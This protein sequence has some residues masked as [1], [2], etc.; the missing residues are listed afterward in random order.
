MH[1][2][3]HP[4]IVYYLNVNGI[5]QILG[6][7]RVN[8]HHPLV[9]QVF[10]LAC[11]VVEIPLG[12][13][14]QRVHFLQN[15]IR[16]VREVIVEV[17]IDQGLDNLSLIRASQ[18]NCN[19]LLLA[20]GHHGEGPPLDH[21]HPV[22]GVLAELA[23]KLQLGLERLVQLHQHPGH[24]VVRR[25]GNKEP[26]VTGNDTLWV[27]L[28]GLVSSG[29]VRVQ[30]AH[31]DPPAAPGVQDVHHLRKPPVLLHSLLQIIHGSFGVN[32]LG[33]GG[34]RHRWLVGQHPPSIEIFFFFFPFR[35][36]D[37]LDHYDI[38]VCS[39]IQELLLRDV[40]VG[41]VLLLPGKR[42]E[43]AT[44]ALSGDEQLALEVLPTLQTLLGGLLSDMIFKAPLT[45]RRFVS[46]R[47][48]HRR[49]GRHE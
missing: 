21:L 25:A 12:V 4:V 36:I 41:H 31:M 38:E 11:L 49:I 46:R 33:R 5:I 28:G 48:R 9:A 6:S 17:V 27:F 42:L 7:G 13:V 14:D 32:G 37:Q 15:V 10:A 34:R 40:D 44:L 26:V 16:V 39:P 24:P 3:F 8:T 22:V 35:I 45:L 2:D 23:R 18:A 30:G 20:Q 47:H 1:P 19:A 43:L 29:D